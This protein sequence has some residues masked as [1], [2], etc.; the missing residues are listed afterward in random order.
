VYALK[1]FPDIFLELSTKATSVI[2]C[3]VSPLQKSQV[4]KLVRQKEKCVC[5]SI[6]DG[7]NDVSMI[8]M[9]NIGVGIIGLEGTQAVRASDFAFK[10]FRALR[11]LISVHGRYS[12]IRMTKLILYS[13]YKNL[14]FMYPQFWSGAYM[15]WSGQAMYHE[16]VYTCFNLVF[17]SVPPLLMAFLEKDIDIPTISKYP[18]AYMTVKRDEYFSKTRISWWFASS[19]YTGLILYF[20]LILGYGEG[21]RSSDGREWGGFFVMQANIGYFVLTTVLIKWAMILKYV[22]SP[23]PPQKMHTNNRTPT[24]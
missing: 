18:Q 21:T 22:P 24:K 17:T 7:A 1:D 16:L 20:F 19:L 10:E 13:F 23:P 3:R 8:Q 14:V 4:V 11:R 9:A 12:Y 15:A 6:G 5:L 2:C